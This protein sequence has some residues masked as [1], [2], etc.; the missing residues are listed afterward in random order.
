MSGD[1]GRQGKIFH[2]YFSRKCGGS[3]KRWERNFGLGKL[4]RGSGAA[5]DGRE[6]NFVQRVWRRGCVSDMSCNTG[7][8]RNYKSCETFG[9]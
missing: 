2:S 3:G 6:S 8:R 1:C 4:R 7:S 9:A 5:S